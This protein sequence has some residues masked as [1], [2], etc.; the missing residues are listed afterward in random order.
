VTQN[1][2]VGTNGHKVAFEI[3]AD[4]FLDDI[5]QLFAFLLL[6]N[7]EFFLQLD[8]EESNNNKTPSSGHIFLCIARRLTA[9]RFL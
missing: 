7:H 4:F 1:D 8:L 5:V 6:V 9:K 3:L 2:V